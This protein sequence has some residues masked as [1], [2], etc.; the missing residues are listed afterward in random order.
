MHL[1]INNTEIKYISIIKVPAHKGIRWNERADRLANQY[2]EAA[3]WPISAATCWSSRTALSYIKRETKQQW[4]NEYKLNCLEHQINN[5]HRVNYFRTFIKQPTKR[6][7]RVFTKLNRTETHIITRAL[8][9]RLPLHTFFSEIGLRS[10]SKC[11]TC[12]VDESINHFIFNCPKFNK[13]RRSMV[14]QIRNRW[15]NFNRFL[16]FKAKTILFGVSR[17]FGKK[18]PYNEID[19]NFQAELWKILCRFIRATN[20]FPSSHRKG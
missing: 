4:E 1:I 14:K 16:D 7:K 5:P 3:K 8:T 17:V 13:Q 2:R 12:G 18:L 6:F 19:E 15:P 10:G 11:N 20:R 9:N